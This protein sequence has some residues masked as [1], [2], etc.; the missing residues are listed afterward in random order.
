MF[1]VRCLSF[2]C[3]CLY[4]YVL[5]LSVCCS[6]CST[7]LYEC[8]RRLGIDVDGR[9]TLPQI[10]RALCARVPES[11][12]S[13]REG[14]LHSSKPARLRVVGVPCVGRMIVFGVPCVGRM[15][16]FGVPCVGRMIVFGVPCVGRM[17]VFGV[18]PLW[19]EYVLCV[20]S[21]ALGSVPRGF[22]NPTPSTMVVT[23][24]RLRLRRS[25]TKS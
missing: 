24:S 19:A 11:V 13:L 22:T 21:L 10:G 18:S 2:T 12:P 16:V 14:R 7:P 1:V 5:L 3:C 4:E 23:G 15:I 6:V 9:H 25:L 20:Y 8:E 17:I